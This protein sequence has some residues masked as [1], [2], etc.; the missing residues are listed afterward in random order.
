MQQGVQTY[1]VFD[2]YPE[3]IEA[4]LSKDGVLSYDSI[5]EE[6]LTR[7][8]ECVL[9]QRVCIFTEM[10]EKWDPDCKIAQE[11]HLLALTPRIEGISQA[12]SIF[13]SDLRSIATGQIF[14]RTFTSPFEVYEGRV[15]DSEKCMKLLDDW[16]EWFKGK[17][18]SPHLKLYGNGEGL[19]R[20]YRNSSESLEKLRCCFAPPSGQNFQGHFKSSLVNFGQCWSVFPL[21]IWKFETFSPDFSQF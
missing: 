7:V 11:G 8:F 10:Y 3:L 16:I 14:D 15:K 13:H 4:R 2:N 12:S 18:Q 1:L 21:F 19:A 6:S 20:Y 5:V 17:E 9:D